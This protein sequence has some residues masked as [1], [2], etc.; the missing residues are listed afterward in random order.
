M[1]TWACTIATSSRAIARSVPATHFKINCV[2]TE[3]GGSRSL[4]PNPNRFQRRSRVER[5]EILLG[6]Q[7]F[8]ISKDA[9]ALRRRSGEHAKPRIARHL[10]RVI[11]HEKT[12]SLGRRQERRLEEGRIVPDDVHRTEGSP[13]PSRWVE[14]HEIERARLESGE[15]PLPS[16][17]SAASGARH[18]KRR[19][20]AR[21]RDRVFGHEPRGTGG[22]R[23][24][25]EVLLPDLESALGEVHVPDLAGAPRGRR[26]PRSASIG[27]E[28]QDRPPSRVLA[29]PLS[30]QAK[31][32]K[33]ER[34]EPAVPRPHV[35]AKTELA[36]HRSLRDF[37]VVELFEGHSALFGPVI[38]HGMEVGSERAFHFRVNAVDVAVPQRLAPGLKKEYRT[39]AVDGETRKALRDPVKEP[40]AVGFLRRQTGE[41]RPPSL[42]GAREKTEIKRQRRKDPNGGGVPRSSAPARGIS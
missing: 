3:L 4:D 10:G 30:P 34:V 23:V 18:G 38:P 25:R 26:D 19:K 42:E 40:I 35:V 39:I 9:A 36:P 12:P 1:V 6:G 29:Y 17:H 24:P 13:R 37:G 14:D 21:D 27:E 20:L 41:E 15:V 7:P 28:V 16:S 2:R 22:K 8:E 11:G 31:I 32:Q 33:E 5:G